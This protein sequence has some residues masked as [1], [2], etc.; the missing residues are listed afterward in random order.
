M[1]PNLERIVPALIVIGMLIAT[2]VWGVFGIVDWL[3]IDDVI[4]V[5]EPIVPEIELVVNDS[6]IDT[7]YIYRTP[8]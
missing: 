5:T 6:V 7:I 4:R 3:F 8:Q 1:T 2:A